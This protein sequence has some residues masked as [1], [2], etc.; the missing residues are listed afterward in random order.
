VFSTST[1]GEVLW[2]DIRKLVEPVETLKLEYAGYMPG[3][4]LG[5]IV[6]EYESTMVKI[7]NSY[8]EYCPIAAISEG[9]NTMLAE[10]CVWSMSMPSFITE[11][12]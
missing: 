9:Q 12:I 4:K 7:Y 5:G 2:W 1:D 6:M 3:Q 11:T 8:K 10:Y